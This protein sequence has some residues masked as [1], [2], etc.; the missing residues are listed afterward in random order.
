MI[1]HSAEYDA[2][3]TGDVR[4]TYIRATLNLVS[5]NIVYGSVTGSAQDAE[6]SRP[7]QVHNGAIDSGDNY[8]TL[9]WNRMTLDGSTK[10]MPDTAEGIIGE[11]GIVGREICGADG[12]FSQPQ[13]FTLTFSGVD[14]LQACSVYF[15]SGI[16]NGTAEDFK[17]E[18]LRDDAVVYT[19]NITGNHADYVTASGFLIENPTAMRVSITRWSIPVRRARITEML[20]G[21]NE[22][23]SNDIFSAMSIAQQANFTNLA[24][25][26]GTCTLEIDNSDKRFEPRNKNS[27]FRSIEARQ[28]IMI[29]IGVRMRDGSVEY[30]PIGKYYQFSG[31]W[32]TSNND[33]TIRWDLV[34]I[35]GMLTDRDFVVPE[36]LP[37]TL[38]GWAEA[39]TSQLGTGFAKMYTIDDAYASAAV[40][41][42]SAEAVGGMKCGDI[43]RYMCMVTGTY[44]GA[45][46]YTG[47]LRIRTLA[48]SGTGI[49]LDNLVSYPT[50]SGNEDIGALLFTLSDGTQVLF[51]GTEAAS[52]ESVQ[53]D[54]PFIHTVEA[55][56]AAARMILQFYGGNRIECTGRGDPSTEIGDLD[57]IELGEGTTAIGRRIAQTFAYEGGVLQGCQSQFLEIEQ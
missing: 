2:A 29:S 16:N 54:N 24:L 17:I 7:A 44:A 18:I 20:P 47:K 10:I 27:F 53:I 40:T 52:N 3:I 39:V 33:L 36:V 14:I 45:D 35:I 56:E 42:K 23:W 38:A 50:T 55:A 21:L 1:D 13:I 6:Y 30:I 25:P 22:T 37:T 28:G 49:T 46:V 19:Q 32:R 12:L 41:A 31:G 8:E 34:D 26:Y 48:N 4:R 57:T 9:E 15:S 51:D 5:P 43:I 11:V